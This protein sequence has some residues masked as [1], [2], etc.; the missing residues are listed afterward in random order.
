MNVLTSVEKNLE[1]LGFSFERKE[2]DRPWGGFWAIDQKCRKQFIQ[3]Y[4]PEYESQIDENTS[5]SPKVLAVAPNKRLSW[6]YHNRRSE[7][8]KVTRGEVGVVRSKSDAE[9]EMDT[10]KS[11]DLVCLD[12]GERH[13]LVGLGDWGIVA[14]IWLHTDKNNPSNED[15]IIR[16]QDDFGR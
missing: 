9:G 7:L 4:F 16:L 5:L 11:Q 6:Q 12:Q 1:S 14:E 3:K 13:R 10:F 15:D 2:L 8:W